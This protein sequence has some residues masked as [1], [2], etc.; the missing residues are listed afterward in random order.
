VRFV[1]TSLPLHPPSLDG[2]ETLTYVANPRTKRSFN[3]I[4]DAHDLFDKNGRSHVRTRVHR[5]GDG[6]VV[7]IKADHALNGGTISET[8]H[9]SADGD[10]RCTALQR[11]LVDADGFVS[12]EERVDFAR[13]PLRL[14][15]DAYPEVLLPF[16]LRWQPFDGQRRAIHAWIVDRFVARVYCDW[17]G[18]HTL[19]VPAGRFETVE[20]IMY[21]DLNDWVALGSVL[22]T[23]AKPFLPKYRMW[24]EPGGARR[25]IRFEGPYGPPGAPEIVLELA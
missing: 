11:R 12:R 19:T 10:L 23:L 14:P 22:N 18:R 25:V 3:T 8:L 15:A 21:P 5:D 7:E 2:E 13:G 4:L 20:M 24:F 9:L 1:T 16:V 6:R 17:A